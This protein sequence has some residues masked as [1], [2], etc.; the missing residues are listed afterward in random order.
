MASRRG[1]HVESGDGGGNDGG[2][3]FGRGGG[4]GCFGRDILS[5]KLG[6][7]ALLTRIPPFTPAHPSPV[8]LP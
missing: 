8:I 3:T 7:A 4:G 6:G 5:P 1:G 2:E